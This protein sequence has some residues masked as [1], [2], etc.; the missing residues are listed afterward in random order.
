MIMNIII[1]ILGLSFLIVIHEFGHYYVARLLK[2]PVISFS[3]GFGPV[4]Y[5]RYNKEGIEFALRA[6]L[7][8]GYVRFLEKDTKHLKQFDSHPLWK[9]SAIV[10][11]GP[12]ANLICAYV[13][14]FAIAVTG[15]TGLKPIV[16][17]VAKDSPADLAGIR[18]GDTILSINDRPIFLWQDFIWH[19]ISAVGENKIALTI[20]SDNGD[21]FTTSINL[22][23][24]NLGDF[25]QN[26]FFQVIGVEPRI[27]EL[28]AKIGIVQK[29]SA[30]QEA[31]L[32]PGDEVL[33]INGEKI[34]SWR[35]LSQQ[36]KESPDTPLNL[37]IRREIEQ[38]FKIVKLILVPRPNPHNQNS[39]LAG[40]S[41]ATPENLEDIYDEYYIT[42]SYPLTQAWGYALYQTYLTLK[43]TV[44]SLYQ[45]LTGVL[46]LDSLGGPVKIVQYVGLSVEVGLQ[47]FLQ[48]LIFINLSLFFFNLL[49][50]PVLDGGHLVLY[51]IEAV[52]GRRPSTRFILNYQKIGLAL[53]LFLFVFVTINDLMNL[54]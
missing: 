32:Q 52:S 45:L 49:P 13:F 14:L 31:K 37:D 20:E 47:S 12:L 17:D 42:A 2:V 3:I 7:L 33:A 50:I 30:A 27:F 36:V 44:T 25:E 46:G 15:V 22:G 1:A 11:A 28:P 48:M 6:I 19:S 54:L 51:A 53:I 18:P 9:R 38:E 24:K 16:G 23:E 21:E 39:G 29:N 26:R 34:T 5:K 4:I 10:I 43:I 41:A 35:E 40:I 8:G